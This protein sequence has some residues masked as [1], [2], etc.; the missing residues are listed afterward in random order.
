MARYLT[1]GNLLVE[2]VVLPDGTRAARAARR[3]CG[4]RG[5]RRPRLRRRR[6]DGR[7][8]RARLPGDAR[9]RARG[10]RPRRRA[11]PVRA[12]DDPASGSRWGSRTARRYT[13]QS[14]NYADATPSPDEIPEALAE[15]LDAV[16]IAPVPFDQMAALRRVGAVA[17]A[18]RHGR[19]ALRAHGP[20]LGAGAR[21][22]STRSCRAAAEAEAL[23]GG[24]PGPG[25]GGARARRSRTAAIKLGAEGSIGTR[26]RRGRP[27]CRAAT[28]DARST[29]PAAATRS[30]AAS[31]SACRD[32]RPPQRRWRTAR[33]QP[34]SSLPTTARRT[35]SDRPLRSA[36]A[37]R[38]Y[39]TEY[40]P[41]DQDDRRTC[42]RLGRERGHAADRRS[43]S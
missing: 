23:L 26:R 14:G 32:G 6:A 9:R 33:S 35:R 24:W 40:D 10:G 28:G 22:R 17:R 27:R 4:L 37:A 2:D 16:H 3:R 36:R 19:P 7:A 21:R 12:R 38:V 8:A 13:F 25:G 5:D 43:R 41:R 15:R 20:R 18:D 30:A 11:D 39:L 1:V 34:A 31:S 42:A 29:R